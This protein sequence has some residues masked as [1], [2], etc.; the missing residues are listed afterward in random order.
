MTVNALPVYSTTAPTSVCVGD[1][2]TLSAT[3]A[4]GVWVSSL[5]LLL[6][7]YLVRP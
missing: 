4:G 2:I 5:V 3:P 7:V 1:A 6:R